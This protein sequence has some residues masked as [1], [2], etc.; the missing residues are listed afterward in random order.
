MSC[1]RPFPPSLPK[2][3]HATGWCVLYVFQ[4]TGYNKAADAG[5]RL[6]APFIS[7]PEGSRW[8]NSKAY[9]T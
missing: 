2:G 3:N 4:P 5:R 8:I 9:S 7:G 1:R 6:S